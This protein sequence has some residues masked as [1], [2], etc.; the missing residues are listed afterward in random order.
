MGICE[1][2]GMTLCGRRRRKP[3]R[4]KQQL[5][6]WVARRWTPRWTCRQR[7][8]SVGIILIPIFH[9]QFRKSWNQKSENLHRYLFRACF[10]FF[11]DLRKRS[12]GLIKAFPDVGG[13]AKQ[14]QIFS[15]SFFFCSKMTSFFSVMLFIHLR[16]SKLR[17][18][19][20]VVDTWHLRMHACVSGYVQLCG[21]KRTHLNL[22]EMKVLTVRISSIA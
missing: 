10:F 2:I 14:V 18:C 19:R 11:K 7:R 13:G 1:G 4:R 8:R 3:P 20:M 15:H 6:D 16:S 22:S 17:L 5:Q 12:W 9:A 21:W